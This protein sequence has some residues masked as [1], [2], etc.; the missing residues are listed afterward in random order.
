MSFPASAPLTGICRAASRSDPRLFQRHVLRRASAARVWE[1]TLYRQVRKGLRPRVTGGDDE[2]K[3]QCIRARSTLHCA[4]SLSALSAL[5]KLNKGLRAWCLNA[6]LG[7][8]RICSNGNEEGSTESPVMLLEILFAI[9]TD[10][11]ESPT[12]A[13]SSRHCR[14]V[15]SP[16]P[17][18]ARELQ[19]TRLSARSCVC[20]SSRPTLKRQHFARIAL[21]IVLLRST[22]TVSSSSS[23][24][25]LR[26]RRAQ[27]R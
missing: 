2:W 9:S 10:I 26:A 3:G 27:P 8:P 12:V 17:K 18:T 16:R 22:P 11:A 1:R 6:M 15:F 24:V 19:I 13:V 20:R 4:A 5:A 21:R 14:A 25:A 23:K 7:A